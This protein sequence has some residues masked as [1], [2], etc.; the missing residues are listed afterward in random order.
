M[1]AKTSSRRNFCSA[2]HVLEEK[3]ATKEIKSR[4]EISFSDFGYNLTKEGRPG[5]PE[6]FG[7]STRYM[8]IRLVMNHRPRVSFRSNLFNRMRNAML[9]L[10]HSLFRNVWNKSFRAYRDVN[11][12]PCFRESWRCT[13]DFLIDVSSSDSEPYYYF[14]TVP[15]L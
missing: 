15:R 8:W 1:Y 3:T 2:I 10:R 9:I 12:L 11:S 6:M 7:K 4:F 14:S 5:Q 13:W